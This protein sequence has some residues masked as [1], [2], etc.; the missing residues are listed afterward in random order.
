MADRVLRGSRL[1]AVSYENERGQAP[2]A[3][4][5]VDFTCPQGHAFDVVFAEEADLPGA[6]DCPTCGAFA[7]AV[8][9]A[10]PAAK[11]TKPARTHWDML[12]ERRSV[13]DLQVL[14][15]E[16]LAEI[17]GDSSPPRRR[18]A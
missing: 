16:R 2:A 6:W 10:A 3:R 4:V 17:R 14:L 8:G 15:D 7:Q 13:S 11:A 1:G 12:L 5:R 18:S 9:G